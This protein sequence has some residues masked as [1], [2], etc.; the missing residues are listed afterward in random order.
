MLKRL[1]L[2]LICL[3][4]AAPALATQPPG[5]APPDPRLIEHNK[6]F[7]KEVIKLTDGVYVA[8]GYGL[9]NS[10]L[11]V[12][13]GGNIIV[14]TM[15]SV[16][17]A[18]PV[19]EAFAKL[20]DQPV[21]AII[22]T[23]NH[24]DHVF[25]AAAFAAGG[26]PLVVSHSSTNYFLDRFLNTISPA[27]ST[28]AMRMFGP[29]LP[30]GYH[31]NSGIGPHLGYKP[32]MTIGLLRPTKTFDDKLE[33]EVAGVKMLLF[34]APGET[35]DQINIWLPDKKA[36]FIGDNFYKT[37]PNLYTIRGTSYR[38][39]TKWVASLDKARDLRPEYLV[40]GHTLPLK[41]ADEIYKSLTNYRDAIQF[42]HDQTVRGINQDKSAGQIAAEVKLPKHLAEDPYLIEYYGMV[43]WSVRSIYDGYM[44]WYS[45]KARDLFPLP[46]PEQAA[47]MAELAG[48]PDKLLAAAQKALD[49]GQA[50]WA[51]E[52]GDDVLQLQPENAQA[53]ALKVK[54]IKALVT[55]GVNANARNYLLTCA[56]ETE[57]GLTIPKADKKKVASEVIR[58]VPIARVF[59]TMMVNL[60]P[61]KS[62]ESDILV[63]F[64]FPDLKADY[65]A[66][67]RRGV[68]EIRQRPSA[69]PDVVLTMD[70]NAFK[71]FMA[72]KIKAK[73]AL[74]PEYAKVEGDPMKLMMFL[75]MFK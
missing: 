28:R 11:I 63:V 26:E 69:K 64:S 47:L 24:P 71:E 72:G 8:V 18:L 17:E 33:L 10:A 59:E 21:K 14:D 13:D 75:E 35:D 50:Q 4:L 30:A 65:S 12:G 37:F 36:L 32:G 61:Q 31:I 57:G 41:G 3:L 29:L 38:D 66:H 19:R 43:P 7:P 44:G 2:L 52:L 39:V 56:L 25:G 46:L 1:C 49:K 27:T 60:D 22:Y 68:V 67:L 20:S 40:L 58:A 51:L 70:S 42:V 74:S 5:D 15:E 9:A 48:G 53:R 62:A 23:H 6:D 45:G 73:K 54:A 55:G 16:E 34:H